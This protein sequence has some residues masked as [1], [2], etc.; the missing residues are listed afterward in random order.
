M[1]GRWALAM[2]RKYSLQGVGIN[3]VACSP[4][5]GQ[6]RSLVH[7]AQRQ[8]RRSKGSLGMTEEKQPEL[9]NPWVLDA[10][11]SVLSAREAN[12]H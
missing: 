10:D 9:Q 5:A 11:L 8:S 1:L 4:P 7:A 12:Y 3:R 2:R 6:S